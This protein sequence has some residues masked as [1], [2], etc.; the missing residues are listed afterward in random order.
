MIP[1]TLHQ[2]VLG[3]E[4]D[5]RFASWRLDWRALHPTWEQRIWVGDATGE[6]LTCQGATWCSPRQE[7]LRR[8]CHVRQRSNILRLELLN[9]FGGLYTDND[10]E[11]RQAVDPLLVDAEAVASAVHRDEARRNLCNSFIAAASGHPWIQACLAALPTKDPGVHLSMG[12]QMIT[13]ALEGQ[14]VRLLRPH[15]VQQSITWDGVSQIHPHVPATVVAIHHFV[16][17]QRGAAAST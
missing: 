14:D 5:P 6:I 15:Q 4:T 13:E 9:A 11:W 10:M 3:P 17:I 12:S 1:R 2:I 7:L 8:A 16:N